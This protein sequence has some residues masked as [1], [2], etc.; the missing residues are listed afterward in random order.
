MTGDLDTTHGPGETTPRRRISSPEPAPRS[1]P[2]GTQSQS[3]SW[4]VGEGGAHGHCPGEAPKEEVMRRTLNYRN[5]HQAPHHWLHIISIK[6]YTA[7]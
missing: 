6:S 5:I 4:G 2:R 3:D 1:T 7:H